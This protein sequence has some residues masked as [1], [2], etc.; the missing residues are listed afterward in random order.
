MGKPNPHSRPLRI[1]NLVSQLFQEGTTPSFDK[2]KELLQQDES[3]PVTIT[4]D[5]W[6][7]FMREIAGS[8]FYDTDRVLSLRTKVDIQ[9]SHLK[10]GFKLQQL[11]GEF[12]VV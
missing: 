7:R 1:A 5:N 3:E 2:I 4:T 10:S 6:T 12:S 11:I 8:Y 9:T